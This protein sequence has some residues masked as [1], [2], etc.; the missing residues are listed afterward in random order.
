M[1]DADTDCLI[2]KPLYQKL[3]SDEKNRTFLLEVEN[4]LLARKEINCI[5][6]IKYRRRTNCF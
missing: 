3:Y 4:I 1:R 5:I 6:V 2:S